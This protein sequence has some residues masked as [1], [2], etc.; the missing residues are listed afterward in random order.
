MV[1]QL[2]IAYAI[3]VTVVTD[4]G[5]LESIIS[6]FF[7][8]YFTFF[9]VLGQNFTIGLY[10][11]IPMKEKKGGLRQMMHMS[12]LTSV[13]YFA[14]QFLGDMVLYICPAIA[15]SIILLGFDE[16]MVSSEIP[17][18]FVSFVLYGVALTNMTYCFTHIFDDP[19]TG[20]KYMALIFVLGLL[21]CPIA[22]SLIFAAIFGFDSSVASA[23]S[24][25]Y[26]ID[27]TLCFA[28]QLYGI[29]CSG[30]PDLADLSIKI[31]GSIEPTL[32]LYIGVMCMQIIVIAGI[33]LLVDSCIRNGYKKRNANSGAD[34]PMLDRRQDVLD[35]EQEIRQGA[36]LV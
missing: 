27:P 24:I 28:I 36:N 12:G 4:D 8:F 35:H 30:K 20:I 13:Q 7:T 5:D 23:I 29:C 2:F 1:I 22:V 34:P 14:G 21:F 10:A 32:G 26:F 25:W 33:N 11:W 16:I 18:F 31:F 19:D 6:I 3:I 15:V 9:L 17:N